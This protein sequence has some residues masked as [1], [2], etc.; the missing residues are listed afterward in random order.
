M[1]AQAV[2]LIVKRYFNRNTRRKLN[3]LNFNYQEYNQPHQH[4]Y[5]VHESWCIH[6]EE[7]SQVR[8]PKFP[9]DQELL[10]V[11]SRTRQPFF[12]LITKTS[13]PKKPHSDTK[14]TLYVVGMS[15]EKLF[16]M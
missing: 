12:N 5:I 11:K 6:L 4:W 13:T 16:D 10:R 14:S 9:L 8:L 7:V 1:T 15:K 3:G 2:L